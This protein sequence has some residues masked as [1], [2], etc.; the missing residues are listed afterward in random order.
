MKIVVKYNFKIHTDIPVFDLNVLQTVLRVI[1]F[2]AF[3]FVFGLPLSAHI[4]FDGLREILTG[5]PM[6]F[7]KTD[8]ADGTSNATSPLGIPPSTGMFYGR[9]QSNILWIVCVF[10][11]PC[12]SCRRSQTPTSACTPEIYFEIKFSRRCQ[13]FSGKFVRA[14]TQC[15]P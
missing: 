2:F 7:F 5:F 6:K 12:T 14:Y 11:R 3:A 4:V 9:I 15:V 1:I 8:R 13:N 10:G